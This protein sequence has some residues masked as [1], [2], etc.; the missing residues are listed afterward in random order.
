MLNNLLVAFASGILILIGGLG[1]IL[2]VLPG[3]PLSFGGLWLY[4]WFTNYEKIS[5]TVLVVFGLLTILT[6]ILDFFAPATGARGYK[7]STYGVVGSLI[8]AFAGA[9]VL[10]PIGI[11]LGPFIGA[12]IGEMIHTQNYEQAFRVAHGSF[13]GFVVGSL[14]KIAVIIGMLA[15][16]IYALV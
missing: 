13:I 7:S 12:F 15:Y 6:F 2:P 1:S 10:G 14:F 8:G 4:A 5:P 11:I 16:F 9:F 3:P